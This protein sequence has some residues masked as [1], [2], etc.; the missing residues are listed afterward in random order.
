MNMF[1]ILLTGA[2]MTLSLNAAQA[3]TKL[4]VIVFPGVQNLPMFA[5]QAKGFFA[6]R[7]LSV[8][9]KFTPNSDELRNGLA[10]GRYQIAHSAVDNAFALKD[11]ANV[12][13]AV[14]LGGDDSFNRLVV[15]PE[16]SSLADL[17]G[18]T[19][20]VDAVNTAYAFQLYEMLR[21]KGLNKGDYEV[22]A[23][24]GTG[25]RLE[26][27]TKDKTYAAAMLNPP[28][29]IRAEKAG[30]KAID[31]AAN[32][33]GAYQG[34]SAFVLRTWGAA[35]SDALVK[36]LQGCIE[37]LRW[38]LDTKNR[39]EAVALLVDRLKLPEDVAGQAYDATLKGFQKDGAL[40]MEG[41]RNVLKLRA[42]FEGG[43][44]ADPAKYLDL[45]Y[46]QKALAGM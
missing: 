43:T 3:Q 37:G 40:D 20:A 35:N 39:A 32:A 7:D 38:M 8:D 24:G 1:R 5:A 15:Q 13:I 34:S 27:L 17:K 18:R 4:A 46:Y 30:L 29:S 12:D 28:F 42:Q 2:V 44:P 25:Q 26:A 21:Q 6:K 10:E 19:V 41:V 11:K 36:Y 33:L 9:L 16:I 31:T 14:V 45:T 22:K 23:V